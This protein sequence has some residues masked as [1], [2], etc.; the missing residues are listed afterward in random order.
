MVF[1]GHLSLLGETMTI[2]ILHIGL[3]TYKDKECHEETKVE[4]TNS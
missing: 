2:L 3:L 4:E 1:L